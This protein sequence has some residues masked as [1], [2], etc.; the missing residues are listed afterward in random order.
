M[1]VSQIRAR[2]RQ[3]LDALGLSMQAASKEAGLSEAYL[4]QFL[5]ERQDDITVGKLDALAKAL[6]TSSGWLLTGEGDPSVQPDQE[7]ADI[8]GIIPH[9]KKKN[10]E[11]ARNL[12]EALRDSQKGGGKK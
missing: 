6:K 9:L 8:I 12:L 2:I 3:R 11:T 7:T 1:P 4:K 10:L 5:S